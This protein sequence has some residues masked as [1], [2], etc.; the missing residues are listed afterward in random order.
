MCGI[1]GYCAIQVERHAG[2][3]LD[4]A[5]LAPMLACIRHRGPDDEGLFNGPGVVLGHRRLSII[6]V[7]GG[8]QP[9]HGAR[10]STVLVVNGEVYNFRALRDE[11]RAAGHVFRSRSDSEVLAHAYDAWGLGFLDRVD[12]MFA[13]ALWDGERRRLVLARDRMG[14]KPL[15]WAERAGRV[16]F[17]SELSALLA[18][19]DVEPAI[20]PDALR[21]YL[22]LEY[23]PS[24]ACIIAGVRKLEP[25]TALVVENGAVRQHRYWRL[26]ANGAGVA[27]RNGGT[28]DFGE[29]AA[30]LRTL[31][32]GSV[33]QRLVSD[34]PLGVF[35]SGG[36]DSSAVAALAARHGPLDTFSI[37]FREAS[38]DESRHARSVAER[39]GSRHHEH[40]FEAAAMADLVPR[41]G[42]TLDEPI[43][44]ASIL[45]TMLLSAFA[46][47]SVTVAL[48]GDGGDE[49]FAGYPMHQAHRLAPLARML[50]PALPLARAAAAR[51][52]VAHGNFTLGFK[53]VTFLR[54][55]GERP[56]L[57]HA[58]WMSSFSAAESAALLSPDLLAR[59][60][61]DPFAA[62][63]AAWARSAGAQ[64][65]AR[66]AHL[67]AVT[68][69]P[70]DILV[71]VD[72]ASMAVALEVRAP[73]LA[74]D[75]VEFAFSLPDAFRMRGFT[76]KRVL[77]AAVADLL[78]AEI[79]ARPKKGFG[80]PI[81]AWLA[82]PLRD[83]AHDTLSERA[84]ADGGLFRPAAV[85]RLLAEHE[86][87]RAD[88][89]KP[90]WTL[91]VF[92]LWRRAH[93]ARA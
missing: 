35:L 30:R 16:L 49:L 82:G 83:L 92:E 46:R 70:D 90:L 7:A 28:A 27:G 25:G 17:A 87:G 55:A 42:R 22:A 19:P 53:A 12:G 81:A 45:P 13:L 9:L 47:R 88:H 10:E 69:L 79:L 5:A 66:A 58:L 68:Y 33:E 31:L 56:P 36:L 29:A 73:F 23:V 39:I 1:A 2:V 18:H 3:P 50:R 44:D 59:A 65:I 84:L 43:G 8:H 15:F 11:L 57:N 63:H 72:R 74:R 71:K 40:I 48:G 60:S 38:F 61:A 32:E 21:A 78:P 76:G 75:V 86:R 80:V 4:A 37:G 67:D 14:E 26:D 62:V 91:L 64:P 93:G 20:D 52:P 89:R 77:R 54:G 51:M 24:P 41:L 85:A 6:D 34:V